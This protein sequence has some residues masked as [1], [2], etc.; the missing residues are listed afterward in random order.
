MIKAAI[1]MGT[2]STRLLIADYKEGKIN[3]LSRDLITTRLG[4]GVDSNKALTEAA[5]KRGIRALKAFKKEMDTYEI[6]ATKLVG[7]SALRDVNNSYE[8]QKLI[9]EELDFNLEVISGLREAE[10]IYQGVSISY[11]FSNFIIVDIGGGSTEF[12]WKNQDE[13]KVVMDSLNIGAVRITERF[14]ENIEQPLGRN[15]VDE[16]ASYVNK[17]VKK[18]ID[19]LPGIDNIIG[20][21]GTITT[22]AA[23]LLKLDEHKPETIHDYTLRY[24]DVN[25]IMDRLRKLDLKRRKKVKGLNPDR[26]D[27]IV[28]GI[29][30]LVE[31]MKVLRTLKLR[32]SNYDILHGLLV[33]A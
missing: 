21:G 3:V 11:D 23:M 10:L 27:I 19:I 5:M 24:S 28:A 32:V 26:A 12:I 14:V 1:E 33:E 16:I 8:F 22:L 17:E 20:V 31:I 2:N 29:I 25:K 15:L 18:E 6:K 9:K 13:D 30:I 7:T 4:E